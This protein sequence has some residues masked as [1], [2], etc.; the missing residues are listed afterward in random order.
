MKNLFEYNFSCTYAMHKFLKNGDKDALISRLKEIES[1]ESAKRTDDVEGASMWF[2]FGS[3]DTL[4]TTID[5]IES[6][7]SLPIGHSNRDLIIESFDRVSK[8]L[9]HKKELRVFYS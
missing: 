2:K 6:A 1:I 4:A 3:D 8:D 7:L 5:D 9:D